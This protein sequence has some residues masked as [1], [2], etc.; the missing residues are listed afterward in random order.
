MRIFSFSMLA[1]GF[2]FAGM[3]LSACSS[4]SDDCVALATCGNAAGT[5][6]A[7]SAGKSG[8][9]GNDAGGNSGGANNTAGSSSSGTNGMSGAGGEG[10]G[11]SKA[12]TGDVSDDAACW[13]S[14]EFGVFVSSEHGDDA[15]GDGTKELPFATIHR[16]IAA[17][18]GKKVY[19]CLGVTKDTYA[20]KVSLDATTD[21]VHIY[22]GFDC[23]TWEYSITRKSSVVSTETIALRIQSLKQGAYI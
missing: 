9:G 16:G 17:A 8:G 20:E 7:G 23:E 4:S 21:G 11:G 5:S 22:G 3:Q 19:V 13:T 1:L 12:C 2:G 15:A 10:G 6:H 18:A 14:N